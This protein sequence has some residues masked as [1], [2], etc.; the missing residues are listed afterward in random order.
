[1]AYGESVDAA[2]GPVLAGACSLTQT[3]DQHPTSLFLSSAHRTRSLLTF[4][5]Y[6]SFI[7]VFF[8]IFNQLQ[9]QDLSLFSVLIS[10]D[11]GFLGLDTLLISLLTM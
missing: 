5:L 4:S 1:M 10:L 3:G 11:M 8:S 6:C 2:N 9:Y 7:E